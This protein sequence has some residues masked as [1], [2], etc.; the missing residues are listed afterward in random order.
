MG[1]EGYLEGSHLGKLRLPPG[2]LKLR[3]GSIKQEKICPILAALS[4]FNVSKTKENKTWPL[5]SNSSLV[6]P[7]SKS[8]VE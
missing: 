4:Y 6:S 3:F 7:N 2:F 8:L 5:V 1:S